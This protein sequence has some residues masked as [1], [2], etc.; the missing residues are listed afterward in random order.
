MLANRLVKSSFSALNK[1]AQRGFAVSVGDK[2]PSV[3][4]P[5]IRHGDNGFTAEKFDVADYFKGKH[6]VFVGYPGAFTPTCMATHIPE[7]I[8]GASKIK[9]QGV[10]E[11]I[12]MS[13]NDPFVQTAFAEHLG[14]K[15]KINFIADG[16]GELTK[17]LGLDM[18]LSVAHLSTRGMR[19]SMVVKDGTVIEVN[20][21][22]G[23]AF[24]EVSSCKMILKQ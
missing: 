5:V 22:N 20:N 15:D 12:A 18:D 23:P 24:T 17:A 3:T 10:D 16:N 7:F 11:I 8:E 9:A 19:M 4:V 14:G 1:T 2:I 6:V 13:V 21:E